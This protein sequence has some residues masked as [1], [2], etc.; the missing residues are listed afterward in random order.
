MEGRLEL[1]SINTIISAVTAWKTV[2]KY[3]QLLICSLRK[4]IH[5][6]AKKPSVGLKCL[7]NLSFPVSKKFPQSCPTNHATG[8]INYPYPRP[9]Y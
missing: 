4:A 7:L 6:H 1:V 3:V 9:Q 5:T 8:P 2:I